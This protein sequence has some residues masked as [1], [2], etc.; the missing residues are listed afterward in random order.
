ML[1]QVAPS[2]GRSAMPDQPRQHLSALLVVLLALRFLVELALFAAIAYGASRLAEGT[3]VRVL[4]GAVGLAVVTTLWGVLLSPRRRVALPLGWRVAVELGLVATAA[5][6]LAL[7][8]Q[9][10]L[11]VAL[12]VAEVVVLLA[13]AA[14]GFPPGADAAAPGRVRGGSSTT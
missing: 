1:V 4:L 3:V 5:V 6:G 11:A 9:A 2:I 7:F 8:G 10:Q 13:L 12:V 14:L